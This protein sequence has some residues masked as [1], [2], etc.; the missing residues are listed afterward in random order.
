MFSG[1][2]LV[3]EIF[4]PPTSYRNNVVGGKSLVVS[5]KNF[6]LTTYHLSLTTYYD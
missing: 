5:I 2:S 1:L 4:P 6:L 3:V